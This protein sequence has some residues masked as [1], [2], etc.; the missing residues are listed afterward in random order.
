MAAVALVGAAYS[1]GSNMSAKSKARKAKK[2]EQN[3]ERLMTSEELRRLDKEQA[4]VLGS[5]RAQIASS[6]FTGYGATSEAY[7][8]DLQKEQSLQKGFTSRVGG[9]RAAAIGTRGSAQ[10]KAYESQAYS[11]LLSGVQS[12]GEHFKWGLDDK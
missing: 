9:Q 10:E 7:L 11:S 3:M 2:Q 6:G 4:Q 5:T 1:F 12:V 8:D